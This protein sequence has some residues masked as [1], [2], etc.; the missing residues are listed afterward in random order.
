MDVW[1]DGP[2]GRLHGVLWESEVPP[3]AVIVICHPHPAHGGNMNSNVVHRAGRALERAGLAVLRFDFRGV[4][5]S[6]G[7]HDGGGE[8][9]GDLAAALAW[10][11][12]RYPGL[13]LWAGGFSFGARTVVG[14][15]ARDPGGV[16]RV[17][18]LALPVLAYPCEAA[19]D[20]HLPG[21]ILMAGEDSFGTKE[22]LEERFPGLCSRMEVDQIE[23][24]D[25]FFAGALE[26]LQERVQSW[27]TKHLP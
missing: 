1:I 13:P 14:L 19:F 7:T 4:R 6:A 10:L 18:L 23:G 12:E 16:E 15:T 3:R 27:A 5:R 9:E 25:H 21:L 22:A 24:V 8:E 26:L 2:A 11:A 20:L 17:L